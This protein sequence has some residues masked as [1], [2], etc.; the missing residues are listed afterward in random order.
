MTNESPIV[1]DMK[2]LAEV[3][4]RASEVLRRG[5]ENMQTTLDALRAR[6]TPEQIEVGSKAR[7]DRAVAAERRK[8]L[9]F[10][11]SETAR[12]RRELGLPC[13]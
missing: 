3:T 9:A 4:K 1:F 8:G 2:A 6:R 12:L 13:D 7:Y 11:A 5:L 10:V